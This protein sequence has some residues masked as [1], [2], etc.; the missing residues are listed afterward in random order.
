MLRLHS[1]MLEFPLMKVLLE[2]LSIIEKAKFRSPVYP[3]DSL[4]YQAEVKFVNEQGGKVATKALLGGRT[5]VECEL[6]FSFHQIDNPRL[7]ERRSEVLSFWLR[8]LQR[9]EKR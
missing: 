3:G 7:E 6:V 8:D 9:D 2:S 4:E 1:H 5:V